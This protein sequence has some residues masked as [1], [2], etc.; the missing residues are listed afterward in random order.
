M[1]ELC[2]PIKVIEQP[3]HTVMMYYKRFIWLLSTFRIWRTAAVYL[4]LWSAPTPKPIYL[5]SN[6]SEIG[7][8]LSM[9]EWASMPDHES[10]CTT[11]VDEQ[12]IVRAT[13]KK[14]TMHASQAYPKSFGISIGRLYNSIA[15]TLFTAAICP[16]IP[17]DYLVD[18]ERLLITVP[19]DAWDDANLYPIFQ[20]L[21]TIAPDVRGWWS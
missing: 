9:T 17:D 19:M 1:S 11:W 3:M 7:R 10:L 5:W 2:E 12:G 6:R 21:A 14:D 16:D 8:I 13:G 15:D 4:G 20:F 18:V